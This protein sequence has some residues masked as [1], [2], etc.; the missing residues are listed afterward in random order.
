MYNIDICFKIREGS[1]KHTL[2]FIHT[3]GLGGGRGG[4]AP[5]TWINKKGGGGVVPTGG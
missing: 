2:N 5:K 4:V 3:K 1:L